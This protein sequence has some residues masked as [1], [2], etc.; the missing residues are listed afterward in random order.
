MH[1]T[2][3]GVP[4]FEF[5]LTTVQLD[6]LLA[7]ASA[8]YDHTCKAAAA[9]GGVVYGWRNMTIMPAES[10]PVWATYR[11]LD[12]ALKI[13]ENLSVLDRGQ[14]ETARSLATS[15][16]VALRAGNRLAAS[17]HWTVDIGAGA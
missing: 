17:K 9:V 2:I 1:F 14:R 5:K 4:E 12:L 8:H 13:L 10:L 11:D 6:I 15:F 16:H 3:R 7:C